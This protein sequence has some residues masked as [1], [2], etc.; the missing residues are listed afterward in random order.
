MGKPWLPRCQDDLRSV[1]GYILGRPWFP[2]CQDDLR[3][4]MV[5]EGR[6]CQRQRG[7]AA[8]QGV[9]VPSYEWREKY[10]LNITVC[11]I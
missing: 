10:C 11:T 5:K 7:T 2:R 1:M 9:D 3:S 6:Q 4:V 8:G